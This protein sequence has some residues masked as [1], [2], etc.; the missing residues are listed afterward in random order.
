MLITVRHAKAEFQN[1]LSFWFLFHAT[2]HDLIIMKYTKEVFLKLGV[3][4][5]KVL[6]S[7]NGMDAAVVI[8][9][10]FIKLKGSSR[11]N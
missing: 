3:S 5:G 2:L 11:P 6:N 10:A 7:I 1:Y 4:V 8:S 9:K